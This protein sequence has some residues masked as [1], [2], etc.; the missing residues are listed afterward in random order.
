[1][2]RRGLVAGC[3]RRAMSTAAPIASRFAVIGAGRMAEAMI[4]GMM[5][6]GLQ[7]AEST[8]LFDTN[9][10]R[11]D[12][13]VKR[14]SGIQTH[15]SATSCIENADLVLVAVKP[16]Q[17]QSVL[18]DISHAVPKSAL[19]VSI[20]AGCPIDMFLEE[21]PTRSVCRA[22]PNTPAVIG[23]GMSVWT[24]TE[25]CTEAQR[26]QAQTLLSCF[27]E[28]LLCLAFEP[29]VC[30]ISSC[31]FGERVC[32]HPPSDCTAGPLCRRGELPRHGDGS[33]R[34]WASLRLHVYGG[35][36]RY[37]CAARIPARGG[38]ETR[39]ADGR[40][41]DSVCPRVWRARRHPA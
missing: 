13:C 16:Q 40:R 38:D 17:M 21:L 39:L 22:M 7:P 2:M 10:E 4:G 37:G 11:L 6:G 15:A 31:T 14:W 25:G 9:P 26:T 19:V 41:L 35:H 12:V 5:A 28:V 1:M 36:D 18:K 20:A 29:V 30:W 32:S 3:S 33:G 24:A 8:H 27:G 23:Q 34:L